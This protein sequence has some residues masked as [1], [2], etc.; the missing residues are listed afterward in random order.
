[1]QNLHLFHSFIFLLLFF[2]EAYS[3]PNSFSISPGIRF[4]DYAEYGDD[5]SFLDGE[6][7]PVLGV[8]GALEH[9]VNNGVSISVFGDVFAGT[10]DYD[11]HLQSG[12]PLTTDTDELFYSL[13]FGVRSPRIALDNK[14]SFFLDIVYQ[15]W[16]RDILPTSIST[17]LFEIYEW[18]E[19]SIGAEYLIVMEQAKR[20]SV[21]AR[22]YQIFN[23][24]MQVDLVS[25]G[26]GKPTLDLGEHIGGEIGFQQMIHYTHKHQVALLG[27][28][29]FWRFGRSD[30]MTVIRDDNLA[31]QTIHEPR[32]ETN[33]ITFQVIFT[34]KF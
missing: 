23:P 12:F 6:K 15:A 3:Q 30:D 29:K 9:H 20:L 31:A 14:V 27:A 7:G 28:Y 34:T 10:V 13:G 21:F 4:F 19:F 17:R 16:E 11:G 8:G 24:T 5:G 25:D 26:Y 2:S 22:A 32:S 18:W 1:M 33:N